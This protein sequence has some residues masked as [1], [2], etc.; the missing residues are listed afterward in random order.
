MQQAVVQVPCRL[1][2]ALLEPKAFAIA[3][4]LTDPDDVSQKSRA[5]GGALLHLDQL[6]LAKPPSRHR[7]ASTQS[8]VTLGLEGPE[9]GGPRRCHRSH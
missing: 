4:V 6:L 3:A 5:T 1:S 8:K 7:S 9:G 2:S